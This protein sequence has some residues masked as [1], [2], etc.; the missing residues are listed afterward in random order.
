LGNVDGFFGSCLSLMSD[1]SHD[2]RRLAECGSGRCGSKG[3]MR[4]A[5]GILFDQIL[6]W[7][8]RKDFIR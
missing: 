3:M 5:A 1:M 4:A 6:N 2:I 7:V 8:P